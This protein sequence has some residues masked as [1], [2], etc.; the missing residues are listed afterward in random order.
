[1]DAP[2]RVMF[3]TGPDGNR[4]NPIIPL[5]KAS[6]EPDFVSYAFSWARFLTLRY[7][8]LH[9]H[10]LE[11][12]LRGRNTANQV[13]KPLLFTFGFALGLVARKKM[14]TTVHN[15]KPHEPVTRIQ[16]YVYRFYSRARP[17]RIYLARTMDDGFIEGRD[18]CIPHGHYGPLVSEED[19]LRSK[20]QE[21][22]VDY[23]TFG[24][25]KPY[26]G[27]EKVLQVA[28][29]VSETFRIVG[30]CD[31]ADMLANIKCAGEDTD[32]LTTRLEYVPDIDLVQE[33]INSKWILL[34]Y[35][36]MY[37]SGAILMAL[38]VGRPV[39]VPDTP[40]NRELQHEVGDNWIVLYEGDFGKNVLRKLNKLPR[41][42]QDSAPD[43]SLRDWDV[44]GELHKCFYNSVIDSGQ[45]F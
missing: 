29:D 20:T 1:M 22:T 31:D 40:V 21:P 30:S 18:A 16:G 27:I 2:T 26:K 6:I 9:V 10:W 38:S 35:N 5:L 3:S 33:I 7:D 43:L 37:N 36:D 8:I 12:I 23:L 17:R 15:L 39:I 11:E 4:T 14:V 24:R 13:L 45:W 41:P 25:I 42:I 44:V 19:M 32:N 34:P 28:R